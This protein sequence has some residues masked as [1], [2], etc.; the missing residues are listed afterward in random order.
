MSKYTLCPS[1]IY[2]WDL[3]EKTT[4]IQKQPSRQNKKL[5]ELKTIKTAETRPVG[6]LHPSQTDTQKGERKLRKNYKHKKEIREIILNSI[7][8]EE[9]ENH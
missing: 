8:V 3:Y 4:D 6:D 7:M 2:D 9:E 1:P 5:Q